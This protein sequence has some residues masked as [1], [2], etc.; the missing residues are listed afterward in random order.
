M[1]AKRSDFLLAPGVDHDAAPVLRANPALKALCHAEDATGCVDVETTNALRIPLISPVKLGQR[2]ELVRYTTADLAVGFVLALS[3]C[4]FEA[5]RYTWAGR[6]QQE[7]SLQFMTH[8]LAGKTLGFVGFG[9][10]AEL[11]APR[12]TAFGL[13]MTYTKRTRLSPAEEAEHG[14]EWAASLPQL[15]STSDFVSVQARLNDTSRGLIGMRELQ[16]TKKTAYLVN[17]ARGRVVDEDALLGAL[18]SGVITGAALDVYADEP[19]LAR[20][21]PESGFVHPG[22]LSLPNVI[23]TAH[24]G[25]ASEERLRAMSIDAVSAL[26]SFVEHGASSEFVLN[27]EVCSQPSSSGS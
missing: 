3:Y 16:V 8:A 10:V 21:H 24:I 2:N 7:H 5:G 15:L 25:G 14:V 17:T 13:R 1:A 26:A 23:L 18:R 22:L 4:L 19:P 12:A 9:R 20:S 6:F 27:P 11:V